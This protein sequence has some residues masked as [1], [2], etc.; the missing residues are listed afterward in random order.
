M[1]VVHV[2]V[3]VCGIYVRLRI[4]MYVSVFALTTANRDPNT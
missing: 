1:E 4:C 3:C 2:Y